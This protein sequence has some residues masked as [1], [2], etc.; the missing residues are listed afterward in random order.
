MDDASHGTMYFDGRYKI[1]AYHNHD[2]GELYDLAEDPGEFD[3][4]WDDPERIGLGIDGRRG[5]TR[6]TLLRDPAC[7]RGGL[8][9]RIDSV[10]SGASHRTSAIRARGSPGPSH[11]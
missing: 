4:L 2:L 1:V 10:A 3:N 5:M 9:C 11:S 7:L 6:S 8:H